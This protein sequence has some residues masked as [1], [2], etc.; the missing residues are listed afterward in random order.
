MVRKTVEEK[1]K[2]QEEKEQRKRI[3]EQ[4]KRQRQQQQASN[5][6]KKHRPL[7]TKV[8]TE[9]LEREPEC[10][11]E[12]EE[13]QSC[14]HDPQEPIQPNKQPVFTCELCA[15]C[16]QYWIDGEQWLECRSCLLCYHT[17]CV[18]DEEDLD[19]DNFVCPA[20]Q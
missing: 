13:E 5:K 15:E 9:I 20:C 4:K 19:N 12:M 16:G 2:R 8:Q 11:T 18:A 3:R 14:I 1:K 7:R 6:R 17:T 10:T